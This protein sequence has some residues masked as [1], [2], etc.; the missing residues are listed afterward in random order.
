MLGKEGKWERTLAMSQA[1]E[2]LARPPPQGTRARPRPRL[3]LRIPG[4]YPAPA[5]RDLPRTARRY[6]P[7]ALTTETA[8]IAP[9][10]P[11][12]SRMTR[13]RGHSSRGDFW[14]RRK[15]SPSRGG[16]GGR[17][18]CSCDL[19]CW[20]RRPEMYSRCQRR[21]SLSSSCCC[22]MANRR[23]WAAAVAGPGPARGRGKGARAWS[24]PGQRK[25]IGQRAGVVSFQ[26]SGGSVIGRWFSTC[27][28]RQIRVEKASSSSV[29]LCSRGRRWCLR[30]PTSLSYTPPNQGAWTGIMRKFRPLF[31]RFLSETVQEKRVFI[32]RLGG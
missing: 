13:T 17:P 10:A 21:Q 19:M 31:R 18:N 30:S 25:S 20:R 22:C 14:Q 6:V 7:R 23:S 11:A 2:Q 4:C 29:V 16:R 1:K 26:C 24:F 3:R 28:T 15:V 27:S 5:A 8:R 12:S 32:E 9:S